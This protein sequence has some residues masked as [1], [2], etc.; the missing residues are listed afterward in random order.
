MSR[1]L[2]VI[3]H[4]DDPSMGI[5]E[6]SAQSADWR[7]HVVRPFRGETLPEP[8]NLEALTVLGGPQS[9]YDTASNPYLKT[10]INYLADAHRRAV[11]IL[12]ICLGSQLL[13]EALGG[14][15]VPG[16]S[17]LECGFIDVTSSVAELPL[18]GRY[19]SFHSD[20]ALPPAHAELLAES[21]CYLQ[22]WRIG[23]SLAV[24][25]HPELDTAGIEA[26]LAIE[27]DK[28]AQFSV[29]VGAIRNEIATA[30]TSPSP[31]EL[32]LDAWFAALPGVGTERLLDSSL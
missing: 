3:A 8:G 19:F 1:T 20:T 7:I 23:G 15:A 21:S 10:E 4:V 22:S 30:L 13:A 2:T 32:L 5:L 17:G 18:Q 31:G 27:G 26:L 6:S 29:D 11:P 25:F 24:Q 28:L 12:A 16:E 14:R 9:A